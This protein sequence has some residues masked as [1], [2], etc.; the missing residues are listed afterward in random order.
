[1]IFVVVALLTTLIPDVDSK[2]STLGNKKIFRPLQFFLK[3]RGIVHS[4]TFLILITLL[5]VMFLPILAF[6]FFLGYSSHLIADSF[7]S[8]GLRPFYPHKKTISGKVRTGGK[9]ETSIFTLF[10]LG[11]LFLLVLRI[12][13]FF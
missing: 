10:V 11:D 4:F 3:H 8:H 9:L 12:A 5:F 6:P 2:N 13:E 7:T 1:M